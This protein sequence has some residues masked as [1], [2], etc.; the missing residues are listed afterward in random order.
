MPV[1]EELLAFE[2]E[3][4]EAAGIAFAPVPPRYRSAYFSHIVGGYSAGYYAYIWSEVLDADSVEWFKENGGMLRENGDHFRAT[5]LSQ[6]GS[7]DAMELFVDFRGR[8]P[9]VQPLLIRRG[10][11][12]E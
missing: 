10:L 4:L 1:A 3:A 11:T 5:L 2:A 7:K 8:E 9:D 12:V 6:G